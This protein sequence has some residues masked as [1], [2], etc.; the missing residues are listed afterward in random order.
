MP[1]LLVLHPQNQIC[2]HQYPPIH[3]LSWDAEKEEFDPSTGKIIHTR[4][5]YPIITPRDKESSCISVPPFSETKGQV[6]SLMPCP[7][8]ARPVCVDGTSLMTTTPRGP[9]TPYADQVE[10]VPDVP[11]RDIA[12]SDD[13]ASPLHPTPMTP[14]QSPLP[15]PCVPFVSPM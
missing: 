11:T 4:V 12:A 13:A 15:M 1:R 6:N 14:R 2:Y 10:P 8:A 7:L 9:P 3:W 5:I